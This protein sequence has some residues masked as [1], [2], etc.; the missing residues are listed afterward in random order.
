[1]KI[2]EALGALTEKP[3]RYQ[4]LASATSVL[5]DN[6]VAVALAFAVLDLTGSATDLGLVLGARTMMLVIF[7]LVGGVWADR[8]SRQKLM[9]ISDVGRA[10]TQGT[11]GLLIVSE[12][13]ELWHFVALEALNGVASAF[14]FPA[15]TGLTPKTVSRSRLQQ[16]NALLSLTHSS[17][18]IAGPVIAGILVATTGPGPALIVDG[19]TFLVSAFFL[20]HIHLPPSAQKIERSTFLSDLKEGWAEVRSRR[21]VWIS[22]LNFMHFQLLALPAVFVLGPFIADTSLGGASAWATI[23]AAGGIGAV[24]GD[25]A[26]IKAAPERPLKTAYLS[27]L[28]ATPLLVT[29][30]LT[31]PLWVIS[32]TAF[33]WGTSMTFFNTFWFTVLQERVPDESLSRVSSYDW[34]GS[35]A[36][37]PLGFALIAPVAKVVGF[38]ETLLGIAVVVTLVELGTAFTPS[39]A[40]IRR[41]VTNKDSDVHELSS[42]A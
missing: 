25:I 40:G 31:P 36:L 37:R 20:L 9:M 16:A 33:L 17:A 30:A 11:L 13:A 27:M 2:R 32:S 23:L 35:T 10:V 38:A 29:L 26:A 34:V 42:L 15:A 18:A 19:A 21:W 22:I 1:M 4:F 7:I 28:L 5:G 3:F 12:I 8:I 24:F 39:V 41:S 14:F 6:I